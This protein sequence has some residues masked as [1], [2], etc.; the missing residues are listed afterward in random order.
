MLAAAVQPGD[1]MKVQGGKLV[2]K[3]WPALNEAAQEGAAIGMHR[4]T[5]H[6]EMSKSVDAWLEKH[7][8]DIIDRIADEVVSAICERFE[9]SEGGDETEAG[10]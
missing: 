10:S 6:L 1:P 3:V 2:A 9:I 5:K 7:R 4:A 8:Q